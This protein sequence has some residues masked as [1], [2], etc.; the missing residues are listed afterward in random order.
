LRMT[1]GR[2]IIFWK[3]WIECRKETIDILDSILDIFEG[4]VPA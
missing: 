1:W 2:V 3:Y 4:Y